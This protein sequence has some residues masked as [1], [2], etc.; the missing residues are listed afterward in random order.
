MIGRVVSTK[1]QKTAVVLIDSR[2]THPL[3]KKSYVWSK[4][5]LAHDE[6]GV[7]LG[8][9][10][11]IVKIRPISKRKH[12]NVTKVVGSDFVAIA[13]EHLK[14]GA[15]EAIAE[16]LPEEPIE[17][18][19]SVLSSQLSD[20]SDPVVSEPVTEKQKTVKP[21]SENRKQKTDNRKKEA[22]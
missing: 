20:K 1:M 4:K 18:Q 15:E 6:L 11:E 17:E 21:K 8:D 14:E 12:W 13:T 19:S 3:Y 9:I 10:V 16:V 5:Y 7:K 22:K 2:K